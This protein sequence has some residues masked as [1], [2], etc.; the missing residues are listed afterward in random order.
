MEEA[1][2]MDYERVLEGIRDGSLKNCIFPEEFQ[3]IKKA[4]ELGYV[5]D[6]VRIKEIFK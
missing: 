5:A 4:L 1:V 2:F 6:K 3:L